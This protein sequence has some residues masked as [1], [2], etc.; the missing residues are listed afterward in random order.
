MYLDSKSKYMKSKYMT[1]SKYISK[2]MTHSH[3]RTLSSED[4]ELTCIQI[5]EVQMHDSLQV[6]INES[7]LHINE[8]KY[9]KILESLEVH[10]NES[11][12][13]VHI[14]IHDSLDFESKYMTHSHSR[15]LSS[16]FHE[17]SCLSCVC[18]QIHDSHDSPVHTQLHDSLDFKSEYLSG[19]SC[20]WTRSRNTQIFGIEVEWVMYLGMYR[21]VRWVVYLDSKSSESTRP[22]ESGKNIEGL[23]PPRCPFETGTIVVQII[24]TWPAWSGRNEK[25]N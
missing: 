1:H 6:H 8:S 12:F 22:Y 20:I 24:S 18:I 2:Y 15:T 16:E 17:L 9:I 14:Q 3:L 21:W 19:E 11:Y 23:A 25:A 7:C 10:M 13:Q 4:H 5:H